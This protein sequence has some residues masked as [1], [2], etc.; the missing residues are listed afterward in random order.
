MF[1]LTPAVLWTITYFA[2]AFYLTFIISATF[3]VVSFIFTTTGYNRHKYKV[4]FFFN[5][6]V[7]QLPILFIFLL[8]L[9]FVNFSWEH[10]S[11]FAWFGNLIFGPFQFKFFSIIIFFFC[12]Y[13]LANFGASLASSR[14][15]Y[16][17]HIVLFNF[18]I[19]TIFLFCANNLITVIFF[20]E[21]L[22]TLIFLLVISGSF[23]SN[24]A[25]NN[26]NFSA[27][28]YFVASTPVFF[29]HS[30]LYFFWISLIASLNLFLFLILFY[31][32]FLTYDWFFIEF[33]FSYYTSISSLKEIVSI[34]LIWLNFLFCLFL[35]CG[36]VP[37]YFWKPIFFKGLPIHTLFFYVSFFYFFIFLFFC[38]FLTNFLSQI[39]FFF[40]IV[41][42]IFLL[43]GFFIF[44]FI[45][46]EAFYIKSFVALS[47]IL[48]STFIFLSLNGTNGFF[49]LI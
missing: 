47:S 36:L 21:I 5:F 42:V 22:S 1:F 10:Q 44:L 14:E 49:F 24:S 28:S 33:I 7:D 12:I 41:N 18:L 25:Y 48:N 13:I 15:W 4:N 27:F 29:F 17:Y 23:S 34:L 31:F 8:I 20:I 19:W 39:F 43:F 2:L 45:L 35:K 40:L 37:F 26:L 3:Y 46:N 9:F 32:K 16:E 38:V 11:I 6:G 30:I